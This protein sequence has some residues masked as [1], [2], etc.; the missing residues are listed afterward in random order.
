M[1][2]IGAREPVVD[3]V[4]R[5]AARVR[6]AGA[7]GRP[8]LLEAIVLRSTIPHGRIVRVDTSAALAV[9]GV[10]AAVTAA[11]VPGSASAPPLFGQLVQDTPILAMDRVRYAG[12]PIA[13]VAACDRDAAEEAIAAIEVELDPLPAV[14]DPLEALAADAPLVQSG[15]N[16]IGE[17]SLR[18]GDVEAALAAASVVVEETFWAPPVQAVPLETHAVVAEWRNGG[19]VVETATQTPWN[20]RRQLAELFGLPPDKVRVVVPILGGGFGA[21]AYPRIEPIAVLLALRAGRPVRLVLS[22]AEEFVTVLRQSAMV[23]FTTGV[24]PDGTLLVMRADCT[25][26][27]GAYVDN[28]PRVIR[29]GLYSLPGPY[30]IPTIDLSVRAVHT[31]LPPCGPLR[32]PGTAQVQWAREAHVDAVAHAV[33]MEPLEFRRRNLVDSGDRFLLGGPMGPVHLPE[34]LDAVEQPRTRKGPLRP[35]QDGRRTTGIGYGVAF[36]TT[37]TPSTSES[38][39]TV[40]GTGAVNVLTSTVD[41]GQGAPTALAQ[42]AAA[43]LTVPV[44]EVTVSTPDTDV[45][46]PDQ[47]TTSSR[48]TFS[49]GRAIEKA[50]E[51]VIDQLMTVA[52]HELEIARSD[53]LL[54]DGRVRPVDG[55]SSGRSLGELVVASGQDSV[56]ARAAFTNQPLRDPET[57][58]TGVSTHHHQAAASVRVEVDLETGAVSVVDVRVATHAGVVVNPTLAELQQEGNAAF[59]LGQALM[60]EIVLDGGQIRN[61]SLADYLIPSVADF[62]DRITVTLT[63]DDAREIHGIGETA[64]PAVLPAVTNAIGDA[65]GARVRAIPATPER[66]LTARSRHA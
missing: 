10:V 8:G 20:V 28:S 19:I 59:G 38:D 27:A 7:A 51:S 58:E 2:S 26:G 30:R 50:A 3:A 61:P 22:R 16:E 37:N 55:S 53:L 34:L 52:E 12:E 54:H 57:G 66:I 15:T 31:N 63:E 40:D 43:A 1:S 35:V 39:V 48:S 42:I 25:F 23:R 46:P 17:Q 6:Y 62:P 56:A 36:K 41:V 49:M 4:D 44:K 32:A 45:T 18:T 24:A 5:V 11:D 64:L 60:E 9:P 47:G 21:K 13:A 33:G 65:I 29:H 14:F